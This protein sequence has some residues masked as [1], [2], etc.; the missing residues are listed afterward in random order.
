MKLIDILKETR[1][2]IT[3]I[4]TAKDN[5]P[6]KTINETIP[7]GTAGFKGYFDSIERN[8]KGVERTLKV[9]AKDLGK[10]GYKKESLELQKIFKKYFVELNV[11]YQNFKRKN[12]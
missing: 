2:N 8:M 1:I 6:F 9:L 4:Q 3:K 11:Q 5:K 10:E 7:L 12:T